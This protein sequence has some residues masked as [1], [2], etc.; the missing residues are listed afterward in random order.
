[1][2]GCA[3]EKLRGCRRR[4]NARSGGRRSDTRVENRLQDSGLIKR[5]PGRGRR[6]KR[7]EPYDFTAGLHIVV[8]RLCYEK[9]VFWNFTVD[10]CDQPSFFGLRT[11]ATLE[12]GSG[13]S[14]RTTLPLANDQIDQ[15]VLLVDVFVVRQVPRS[16]LCPGN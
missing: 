1:M 2:A 15:F 11:V 16:D 12:A 5:A 13:S 8:G 10:Q 3:R 9:I 14:G 6:R 4:T 7:R